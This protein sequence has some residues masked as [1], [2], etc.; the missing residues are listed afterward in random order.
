[1]ISVVN[2]DFLKAS[3]LL[4]IAIVLDMMDG[5]IARITNTT[6]SFGVQ[7][8]SLSDLVSFGVAPSLMM[9][10][11]ILR[12]LDKIGIA[13]AVLLVL[14]SAL[15]L[16]RFNVIAKRSAAVHGFFVGLPTP[17]SAGLLVFFVLSYELSIRSL[18]LKAAPI[19]IKSVPL[20]LGMMP[21]VMI[22]LS[23]LMVSNLP[24]VSFKKIKFSCYEKFNLLVMILLLICVF[25]WDI[26]SSIVFM[27]FFV[28]ILSGMCGYVIRLWKNLRKIYLKKVGDVDVGD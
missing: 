6:S 24:Y 1:M 15:R 27:L 7:L 3:W 2:G 17:A 26:V 19:L 11:F 10:Q 12:D 9:Y 8:D 23:L 16:A 20:L 4:A 5:R 25:V 14:C 28:Y 21:V 13:I 22:V 18:A